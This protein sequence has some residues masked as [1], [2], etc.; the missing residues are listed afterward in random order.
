MTRD[1][2]DVVGRANAICMR[3]QFGIE[4]HVTREFCNMTGKDTH[5]NILASIASGFYSLQE[6]QLSRGCFHLYTSL[7]EKKLIF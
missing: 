7:T 3:E 4:T 2:G 1:G 5:R 6:S